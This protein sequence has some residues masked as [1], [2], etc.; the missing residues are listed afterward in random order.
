MTASRQEQRAQQQEQQE[1]R[2]GS[3]AGERAAGPR[4]ALVTGATSG[5]GRA[6]AL[7]LHR[8]GW[9]VLAHG[10]DR[11]RL[12]RLAAEA[13]DSRL[14]TLTADL[15]SLAEVRSLAERTAARGGPLH[16]LVN[17]AAVGFG[18]PGAGRETSADGHELRMAVN[19][20]A[21]T[22]LARLLL[23]LLAASA[24]ARVVAVGSVGQVP[25][26][27]GDLA[28]AHGYR[29][30][31]AYRRSKLALAAG[32]FDLAEAARPLG[33][34]VNCVHPAGFMDTPMVRE[35]G[36]APLSTVADGLRAVLP[37]VT[38]PAFA[39]TTG[40]FFRGTE[41]G[42]ALDLA[43]D[44]RFRRDLA[45][46]TDRALRAHMCG[47]EASDTRTDGSTTDE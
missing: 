15:A 1:Q 22:L 47:S 29:G 3:G 42:R 34:T 32:T 4:T 40:T 11:G 26:A 14:V 7:A 16:V 10:R 39:D 13:G 2:A 27:V 8:S 46:A 31:E 9:T 44:P 19:Y 12:A 24:P 43:Y 6:L 25:F 20:L 23:P 30:V 36:V 17:N 38:D 33:V 35:S 18:P 41:P 37:L 45:A 5:L 21:P 28:F